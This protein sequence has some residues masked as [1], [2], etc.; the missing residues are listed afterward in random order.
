MMTHSGRAWLC[1]QVKGVA[2]YE[3]GRVDADGRTAQLCNLFRPRL[4]QNGTSNSARQEHP[5]LPVHA[6]P[7]KSEKNLAILTT[8]GRQ[9]TNKL[10][11]TIMVWP[12]GDRP[13]HHPRSRIPQFALYHY[14]SGANLSL[15]WP[16]RSQWNKWSLPSKWGFLGGILGVIALLWSIAVPLIQEW[17]NPNPEIAKQLKGQETSLSEIKALLSMIPNTEYREVVA[18]VLHAF[19]PQAI[20]IVGGVMHGPDG[21]R[22]VDIVIQ[23]VINRISKLVAI[24]I[25]DLP[26][27][28]KAGVDIIDGFD[29][30]KMDINVD[31]ALLCSNTGFDSI[32]ISK[33]K[34]KQ[35]GLISILHSGDSKVK[36]VIE[37]EIY[38]RNIFGII[39]MS[40]EIL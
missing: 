3:D 22:K 37:E 13:I 28:R 21:V 5:R 11:R 19:H 23:S 34:R 2:S 12:L 4:H 31:I 9:D 33:A 18:D 27:G 1:S 32:A 38:L 20:I 40:V 16:S 35:I 39:K 25:V 24:D 26:P 30:K 15:L 29:S 7:R 36:A 6:T 17:T 10:G 8:G 14:S